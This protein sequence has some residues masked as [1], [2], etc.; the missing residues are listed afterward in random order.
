M[1]LAEAPRAYATEV[2]L[3]KIV[4]ELRALRAA[5]QARRYRSAPPDLPS[6]AE[7]VAAVEGLVAALFPRHFGPSGLS[8]RGV[9]SFVALKLAESF[10]SLRRQIELELRLAGER[11]GRDRTL[12]RHAEQIAAE[13]AQRLPHVRALLDED[14]RAAYAGDPSAK[15][16]DEI[17]FCFP[18]FAAV[19]RHRLAHQ[20]Y[21][22]GAP[23]LARIVA[24]KAHS[25][26]GI[27]IHPGAEIAGGFFIDHGTGVVI[28][29]TSII[30]R[31]VRLYQAVTLGA[32]RFETDSEGHLLKDY[33]RHPILEDDVV[34]Y[35]GAT[36]L[37][38]VTI[39]K[40]ASIGGN[41]W[42]T[43]S[44]PEGAVVTQA[45]AIEDIFVDG[46]G[47]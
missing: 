24:E 37:G 32:K 34:I 47:I 45:K 3:E 39:G 27:D 11:E 33:P 16:I 21:R 17:I 6:R 5:A 12:S 9:D 2:P 35:A 44:V 36:V 1:S 40:G 28:G 29:E 22:L 26:T 18:G 19:T 20:L 4:G 23:M 31:N 15:S 41:V 42:L 14:I 38:R 43:H 7:T 13:F 10:A 30:G 46:A 25:E 8:G